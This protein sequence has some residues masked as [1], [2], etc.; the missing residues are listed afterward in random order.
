MFDSAKVLK[1]FISKKGNT[2]TI[3]Y[4]KW[5]DLDALYTYTNVLSKEDTFVT[6]NGEE[7]SKEEQAEHLRKW[8]KNME[9]GNGVSIVSICDNNLIAVCGMTRKTKRSAHMAELGISTHKDFRDEG[10]GTV[11]MDTA[12][13]EGKRLG[14]KLIKLTCF[15]N[16]PRALHLYE[17]VG[18]KKVGT[19]PGAIFYKNQYVGEV[20]MYKEL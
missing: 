7:I 19:I 2:I 1:T 3:R 15:E 8:L 9:S 11:L 10:V 20:I 13:E 6:L 5:E 18:F 14:V 4:I 17:K 12:V 16:N